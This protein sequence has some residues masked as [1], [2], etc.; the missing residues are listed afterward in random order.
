M[1]GISVPEC[2]PGA[3][4]TDAR[5]GPYAVAYDQYWRAGW[6]GLLPLPFGSKTPP[7]AGYTGHDAPDPSYADVSA[8]A[9][10]GQRNIALRLPAGVIGLDFDAYD[11]KGGDDTRAAFERDCGPLPLTWRS[12]SRGDE[13]SGIYLYRVPE[14]RAWVNNPGAGFETVQRGHRYAVVWPSNHPSGLPYRWF[15]PDG[16][17]ADRPPRADELPALPA[18]WVAALESDASRTAGVELTDTERAKLMDGFPAGPPCPHIVAARARLVLDGSAGSRYDCMV[19]AVMSVTGAGRRGCP[20][21]RTALHAMQAEYVAAV[22]STGDRTATDAYREWSRSLV[23]A[24]RK[25]G[26]EPAGTGCRDAWLA[27]KA[28]KPALAVAFVDAADP[29]EWGDPPPELPALRQPKQADLA[30][31]P[32]VVRDVVEAIAN[33]AST[34]IELPL[35]AA[36]G[37][38]S[39]ATLGMWDVVA[40]GG[41]TPGPT[42]VWWNALA[43]SGE[44]KGAASRRI[45]KPLEE[46][47]AAYARELRAEN[48]RR[49]QK[50]KTIEAALAQLTKGK[51]PAG[52]NPDMSPDEL[53]RLEAQYLDTLDA[54]A[55]LPILSMRA[56]DATPESLGMMM[57]AQHGIAAVMSPEAT[58]WATI[59]GAYA[60]GNN[61]NYGL[62]NAGYSGEPFTV[63]RATREADR[64]DRAVCQWTTFAQ[65]AALHG[66]AY[67]ANMSAA[68]G[69]LGR[70]LFYLP[71]SLVGAR[72]ARG[73]EAPPAALAAFDEA[74][75]RLH[76]AAQHRWRQRIPD[77]DG[78]PTRPVGRLVIAPGA[79]QA[80]EALQDRIERQLP[81]A[82]DTMRQ[83]LTRV[84]EKAA[85]VAGQFQ[86]LA[87]PDAIEVG[88]EATAAALSMVPAWEDHAGPALALLTRA[89]GSSNLAPV[90]HA[91]RAEWVEIEDQAR[92]ERLDPGTPRV[93]GNAIYNRVAGQA[94]VT[95]AADVKDALAELAARNYLRGPFPLR[96]SRGGAPS[97]YYAVHPQWLA[98]G[99]S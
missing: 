97:D 12:T 13:V 94:W 2:T 72:P 57:S 19:K 11:G 25:V 4:V 23:G 76:A 55:P 27:D 61:G 44:R 92:A 41:W 63:E 58:P 31:L 37:A 73:R 62:V 93:Q 49:A 9:D 24:L 91:V 54:L 7:P 8:W 38:L 50:R 1:Y 89:G 69:F 70:H 30:G 56:S 96:G 6:R 86:L 77:D 59:G 3:A 74:L 82:G 28:G 40:G 87:N 51:A 98:G 79:D 71:E 60:K 21:A 80:L 66:Y 78:G 46:S 33:Q 36:M 43:A 17:A 10:D 88:E 64:I 48:R 75:T 34:P 16:T 15:A 29:D 52:M 67:G 42:V 85:R 84:A 39:S 22:T 20:G 18:A 5:G 47:E 81:D 90:L 32:V 14:G 26:T 35:V 99:A 95:C 83:W 65:P 68:S 53:D 45:L